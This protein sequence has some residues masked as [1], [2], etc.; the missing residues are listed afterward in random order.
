MQGLIHRLQAKTQRQVPKL[1]SFVTRLSPERA[2]RHFQIIQQIE[3]YRLLGLNMDRLK[4]KS[5]RND[6]AFSFVCQ[7]ERN[8][9]DELSAR[10]MLT[11][12]LGLFA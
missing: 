4:W 5:P 2:R 12:R 1:Q 7:P 6:P 11:T 8:F 9:E 3:P 10:S